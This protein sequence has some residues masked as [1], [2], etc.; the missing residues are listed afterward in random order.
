[1]ER[2][3]IC[4]ILSF[5]LT[6]QFVITS[7]VSFKAILIGK[8]LLQTVDLF[9]LRVEISS[10]FSDNTQVDLT[11]GETVDWNEDK[12]NYAAVGSPISDVVCGYPDF[13][14]VTILEQPKITL[15]MVN[16][17]LDKSTCDENDWC[18]L[19]GKIVDLKKILKL[20]KRIAI[21]HNIMEYLGSFP[22]KE[23]HTL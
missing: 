4:F 5:L 7:P 11:T 1:M 6:R 9:C 12:L 10:R 22:G 16:E 18:I 2:C 15:A 23:Y 19:T 13:N 3:G 14:E 8:T 17:E 21:V 20:R